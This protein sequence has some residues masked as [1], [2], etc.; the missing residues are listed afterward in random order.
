MAQPTAIG[1]VERKANTRKGVTPEGEEEKEKGVS[2]GANLFQAF[3]NPDDMENSAL[4]N[5][6]KAFRRTSDKEGNNM[7][8]RKREGVRSKLSNWANPGTSPL[9]EKVSR[10]TAKWM[11]G[12]LR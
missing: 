2:A 4:K 6:A 12:N 3:K 11:T 7:E 10:R 9:E 1:H 8:A 5:I